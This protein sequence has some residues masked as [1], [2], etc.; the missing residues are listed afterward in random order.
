MPH[1]V[2]DLHIT[3]TLVMPSAAF[4][5]HRAHGQCPRATPWP[6]HHIPG[7]NRTRDG[8]AG[9]GTK[10]QKEM[11]GVYLFRTSTGDVIR[12][13]KVLGSKCP[14]SNVEHMVLFACFVTIYG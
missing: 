13:P 11:K 4:S 7:L 12:E 6:S 14:V 9:Q 1:T 5:Y 8:F 10:V 3:H 2:D